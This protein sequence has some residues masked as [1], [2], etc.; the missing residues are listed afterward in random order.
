MCSFSPLA[1]AFVVEQAEEGESYLIEIPDGFQGKLKFRPAGSSVSHSLG[2]FT[3]LF[4][5]RETKK[6]LSIFFRSEITFF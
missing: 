1:S 2:A 4:S 3:I 5:S 6:S